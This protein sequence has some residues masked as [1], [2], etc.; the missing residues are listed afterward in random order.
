[1]AFHVPEWDAPENVACIPV[2]TDAYYAVQ[3]PAGGITPDTRL[4]CALHGWGQGAR[5]FLRRFKTLEDQDILVLAPQGPHQ[6]Y[7]DMETRKVGF[8]WLTQYDRNRTVA[9]ATATI[10]A[11]VSHVQEEY[12]VTSQPVLLGFSQGVSVAYRYHAL[13]R[14]PLRGIV[15]CGGDLPP[16][17]RAPMA[18]GQPCPVMLVHGNED[19]I[20]PIEKAHDAETALRQ[21]GIEPAC[22][23]FNG[24]HELPKEIVDQIGDWV[25]ALP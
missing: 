9:R 8:S 17:V 23:Y 24:G 5:S 14:Y 4:L 6:F 19:E 1:M 22:L 11:I 18:T 16:D 2:T 25:T 12:G 15:A 10:Q 20:V 21:C 7:L 3:L 13:A